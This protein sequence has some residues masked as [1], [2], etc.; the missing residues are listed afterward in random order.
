MRG[1]MEPFLYQEEVSAGKTPHRGLCGYPRMFGPAYMEGRNV[2]CDS[3]A[4]RKHS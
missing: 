2:E 4:D 3:S 1:R